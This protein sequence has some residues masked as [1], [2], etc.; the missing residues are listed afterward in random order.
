[1]QLV[2]EGRMA[3]SYFQAYLSAGDVPDDYEAAFA[4]Q[5]NGLAGG[6][7]LGHL[8]LL[9]GV[10]TGDVGLRVL[11]CDEPPPVGPEW[12]DLVET[13][14]TPQWPEAV[15][16]GCL[17]DAVCDLYLDQP[18]YR[19][20]FSAQGIDAGRDADVV[21]A[22]EP[23]VDH[24]ELVL[25]PA[26]PAPDA[27][28]R[29]GSE[30]ARY[31]HRMQDP[32]FARAARTSATW[33]ETL[34]PSQRLLDVFDAPW[35]VEL[36]RDL[37]EDLAAAEP[38]VQRAVAYWAAQWACT[39]TGVDRVDWI[40]AV[41]HSLREDRSLPALFHDPDALYARLDDS[42]PD[43]DGE[44]SAVNG[45]PRSRTAYAVSSIVE[46]ASTDPLDAVVS[47]LKQVHEAIGQEHADA[48]LAQVREELTRLRREL[49]E[50]F[51]VGHVADHRPPFTEPDPLEKVPEGMD[52]E[53]YFDLC[54]EWGV[55][56]GEQ[57]P[58]ARLLAVG[59]RAS[60][61]GRRHR[62]LAE[63]L[64]VMPAGEQRAV[65]VWAA[66]QACTLAGLAGRD[67]VEDALHAAAAGGPLPPLWNDPDQVLAKVFPADEGDEEDEEQ[68]E[69]SGSY[70][71]WDDEEVHEPYAP[72]VVALDA[73]QQSALPDPAE[74]VMGAVDALSLGHE[75]PRTVLEDVH[76]RLSAGDHTQQ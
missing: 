13:T 16:A 48:F 60:S 46:A 30:T 56:D 26:P 33:G 39:R 8:T 14:F 12:E 75:K 50:R 3:V 59:G 67:W 45:Y 36:D 40:A 21:M 22:D 42:L 69:Y 2:Y 49:T 74:A 63:A 66:R 6:Q 65:A 61:V 1:M 44:A 29:V 15:L 72:E 62:E 55:Q 37:A 34:L 23:L 25:W 32:A 9:V 68:V 71:S 64:A 7:L 76:R 4:G 19:A 27:I 31:R 54:R 38:G 10:H 5:V 24:Y 47:T 70:I 43:P 58:S 20:R 52:P 51:G 53:E 35:L 73:L 41:L 18:S 17:S 57:L 11:L 28:V